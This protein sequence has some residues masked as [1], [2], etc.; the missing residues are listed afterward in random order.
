YASKLQQFVQLHESAV[1]STAINA[2]RWESYDSARLQRLVTVV[3]EQ[4]PALVELRAVDA[5]GRLVASSTGSQI[6]APYPAGL[7]GVAERVELRELRG[8]IATGRLPDSL[9]GEVPVLISAYPIAHADTFAGYALGVIDLRALPGPSPIPE[10]HERLLVSDGL[11]ALAFDGSTD[12]SQ[13]R[14]LAA[15][16]DTETFLRIRSGEAADPADTRLV[17]AGQRGA[18]NVASGVPA[19]TR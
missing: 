3:R 12:D 10:R 9:D 17:I 7:A 19:V 8:T 11:V 15:D 13:L 1:R 5:A 14:W 6:A 16:P 18:P 4:F 2:Q